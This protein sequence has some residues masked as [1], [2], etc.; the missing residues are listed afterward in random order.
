MMT[1]DLLTAEFIP[2]E[3]KQPVPSHVIREEQEWIG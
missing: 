1:T 3:L 2:L